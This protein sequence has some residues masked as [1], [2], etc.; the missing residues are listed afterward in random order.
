MAKKLTMMMLTAAL[1]GGLLAGGLWAQQRP[2]EIKGPAATGPAGQASSD[3]AART[4]EL[5]AE[6]RHLAKWACILSG[7][8]LVGVI[9]VR[10]SLFHLARNQVELGRLIQQ[11]G[12]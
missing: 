2:T 6:T 1:L 3:L 8:A 9:W 11:A 7:L 10:M 5:A 12:S 4:Y